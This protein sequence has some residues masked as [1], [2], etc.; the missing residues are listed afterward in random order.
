MR[1]LDGNVIDDT[2]PYEPA[3]EIKAREKEERKAKR[4]KKR[5]RR[6]HSMSFLTA[7]NL[8]LNNLFTKLT[9]T[10]LTSFAGSIGII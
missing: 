4:E 9:R 8:S 5:L 7:L 3:A 6:K 2:D 10:L 1:L